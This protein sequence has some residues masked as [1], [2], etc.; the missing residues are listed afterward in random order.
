M[1]KIE[2]RLD[3]LRVDAF[4][5]AGPAVP[6]RGT[7]NA[8]ALTEVTSFCVCTRAVTCDVACSTDAYEVCYVPYTRQPGCPG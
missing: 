6:P 7:V 4:E 2:L 8:H 1:R 5:T 3:T